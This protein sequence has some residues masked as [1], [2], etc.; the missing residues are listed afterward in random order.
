MLKLPK[1]SWQKNGAVLYW[2]Q[3]GAKAPKM[4]G[5]D[6]IAIRFAYGLRAVILTGKNRL[7]GSVFRYVEV[8]A[9]KDPGGVYSLSGV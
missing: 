6:M 9:W 7:G 4:R 2:L 5:T 8:G 3:I 1:P